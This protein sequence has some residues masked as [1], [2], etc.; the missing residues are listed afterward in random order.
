MKSLRRKAV[1]K[2]CGIRYSK[3]K[4]T[5]VFKYG[6]GGTYWNSRLNNDEF[7]GRIKHYSR[8]LK[9]KEGKR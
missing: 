2:A 9:S 1:A 5:C 6:G 4:G 7:M 3:W 8:L